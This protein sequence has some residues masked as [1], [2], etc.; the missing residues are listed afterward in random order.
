MRNNDM[1]YWAVVLIAL[2]ALLL[3]TQTDAADVYRRDTV[4]NEIDG[5]GVLLEK[6]QYNLHVASQV[7]LNFFI[8]ST[9]HRDTLARQA[10]NATKTV[11]SG[12]FGFS[13]K[14]VDLKREINFIYRPNQI[15]QTGFCPME[16]SAVE[17]G[18]RISSAF[19]DF[20]NKKFS[21]RAYLEGCGITSKTDCGVSAMQCR[22]GKLQ[23]IS[24][25]EEVVFLDNNKCGMKY[26]K[27]E[28][29]IVHK[30]MVSFN[31][32]LGKCVTLFKGADSGTYHKL[33]TLGYNKRW[34][35]K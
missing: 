9:C 26:Y 10:W 28:K 5:I 27:D 11:R 32:V 18:G 24:F 3:I 14:L 17:L 1:S 20:C 19:I 13:R 21:L 6:E 33:T 30:N 2:A 16:L 25:D 23:R 22:I 12:I 4:V 34:D 8:Q 7:N 29:K 31:I 35:E 15:E